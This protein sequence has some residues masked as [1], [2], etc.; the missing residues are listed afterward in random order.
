MPYSEGRKEWTVGERDA[1]VMRVSWEEEEEG[2]ERRRAEM[3]VV[4]EWVVRRVVRDGM[5]VWGVVRWGTEVPSPVR[6][7]GGEG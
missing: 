3:M 6:G 7:G 5:P 1:A 2:E 4:M